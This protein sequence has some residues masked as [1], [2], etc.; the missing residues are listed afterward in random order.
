VN[1]GGT[2]GE[3][4]HIGGRAITVR[5]WDHMELVVPNTEIFTKCFT[6]WTAKDTIIRSVVA[7]KISRY[8]N[9]HE[10]KT[11]IHNVLSEHKDILK[12]PVPEVYLKCMTDVLMEFELRYYVNIRL[13]SS[14]TSVVSAVLM[15]IWDEFSARGIKP[16]YPQHEI[17]LRSDSPLLELL[18]DSGQK[19][20]D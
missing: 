17:F 13:V 1:I 6:N 11:L 16:P 9:P 4:T 10:I 2:E 18:P 15:K 20:S 14:R 5:T 7:I 3:V 19:G 12:E 8:D